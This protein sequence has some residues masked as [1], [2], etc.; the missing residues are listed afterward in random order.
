MHVSP[1]S[2]HGLVLHVARGTHGDSYH[3]LGN[4]QKLAQLWECRGV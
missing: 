1:G 4:V 3:A 2:I